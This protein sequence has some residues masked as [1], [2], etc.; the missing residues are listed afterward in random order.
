MLVNV[1]Y[2]GGWKKD[3]SSSPSTFLKKFATFLP[4]DHTYNKGCVTNY[5]LAIYNKKYPK[6]KRKR[7]MET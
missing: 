1:R 3:E 5:G 2:R 6:A 4:I 7:I